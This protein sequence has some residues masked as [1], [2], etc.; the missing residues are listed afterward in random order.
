MKKIEDYLKLPYTYEFKKEDDGTYF[1]SVKELEGCCSVGDTVEEALEMIEDAKE[2]WLSYS[3]EKGLPIPEPEN[4]DSKSYSGKF[5]VRVTPTLHKQLSLQAKSN[6]VSLNYYVSEIL[7]GKSSVIETQ[8][9][10]IEA[11]ADRYAR[12]EI[13][14]LTSGTGKLEIN[15]ESVTTQ[16]NSQSNVMDFPTKKRM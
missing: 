13:K 14:A 1:I 10:F 9:R 12:Q 6:G 15:S 7:A 2:T 16:W 11:I 4:I 5:I 3:L 8:T